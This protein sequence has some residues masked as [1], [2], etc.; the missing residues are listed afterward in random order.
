MREVGATDVLPADV[1]EERVRTVDP[2]E[3]LRGE[4]SVADVEERL[5]HRWVET[6]GRRGGETADAFSGVA[7]ED[8]R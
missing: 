3:R 4:H 8:L 1:I 5:R 2:G 6:L 7:P